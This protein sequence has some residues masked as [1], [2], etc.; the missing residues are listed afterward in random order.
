MAALI[1]EFLALPKA[2]SP[3]VPSH[4]EGGDGGHGD[5]EPSDPEKEPLREVTT[6]SADLTNTDDDKARADLSGNSTSDESFEEIDRK[7]LQEDGEDAG[8]AGRQE[9]QPSHGCDSE[10]DKNI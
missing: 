8:D 2:P 5:K 7:E 3:D 4:E 9:E 1:R 10:K 6:V